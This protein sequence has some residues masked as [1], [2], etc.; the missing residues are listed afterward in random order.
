MQINLID[1]IHIIPF[2][3]IRHGK[4]LSFKIKI[5]KKRKYPR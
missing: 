1:D 3:W 2:S 4:P 5:A